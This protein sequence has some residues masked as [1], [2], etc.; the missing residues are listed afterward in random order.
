MHFSPYKSLGSY[1]PEDIHKYFR[2]EAIDL[3][4]DLRRH[5]LNVILVPAPEQ[6]HSGHMVRVADGQNP[7]WY[8]DLFEKYSVKKNRFRRDTSIRTLE[9]IADGRDIDYYEGEKTVSTYNVRMYKRKKGLGIAFRER[10]N[11]RGFYD[12]IYRDLIFH[13]LINGDE[14]PRFYTEINNVVREFFDLEPKYE[15]VLLPAIRKVELPDII[16]TEYY[17]TTIN[18]NHRIFSNEPSS[19][20]FPF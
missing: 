16:R 1:L 2:L 8:Q 18:G 7:P 19:P 13:R 12:T 15:E 20:D 4:F 3:L 6:R 9:K 11:H 17:L 14:N 5:N 10:K